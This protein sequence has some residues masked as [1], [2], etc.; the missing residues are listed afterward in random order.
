MNVKLDF[1]EVGAVTIVDVSGRLTLGESV[2]LL[3]DTLQHMA[4]EG[5]RNVLL[6]LG[7]LTYM[8]SSGIGVLVSSFATFN[9]LDGRLKLF[10]LSSRVKDLLLL[11][12][13][14]TVF[15]V[16]NDE[17]SALASFSQARVAH[18]GA[19]P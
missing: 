6:N 8:D 14:Y 2:A 17:A 4:A 18:G 15:E 3:R 13:L 7:E 11:T 1:R 10:N 16:Y 12:K 9:N 19:Q 5:R